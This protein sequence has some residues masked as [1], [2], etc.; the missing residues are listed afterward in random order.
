MKTFKILGKLFILLKYFIP[1]LCLTVLFGLAGF[2]SAQAITVLAALAVVK[3]LGAA[4]SLSYTAIFVAMAVCGVMRGFLRY[5][6]HLTG[7][8]TA[9]KLLAVL[10]DKLFKK[11]RELSP[12]KLE[13]REKGNL[14]SMTTSDIET[15]EVFYAHTVAPII[16]YILHCAVMFVFLGQASS[17]ALAALSVA[18]YIAV[19]VAVPLISGKKI[20]Q[21]GGGYRAR[22]SVF[23]SMFMDT[24]YG[25]GV[26][27]SM[28]K[29]KWANENIVNSSAKIEEYNKK[30]KYAMS[31][32]R[33]AADAVIYAFDLLFLAAGFLLTVQG[34]SVYALIVAF[35]AFIGSYGPSAALS[36]LPGNLS[37][38]IASGDR[39]L[40]LLAEQPQVNEKTDGE[41]FVYENLK[42]ENLKFS[43]GGKSVL[44]GVNCEFEKNKIYG[45]CGD[46]GCGKSTFLKVIMRFWDADGK[47][48]YNGLDIK[49]INTSSLR[50]NISYMTQDTHIFDTTLRENITLGGDFSQTEIE[51]ACR[52]AALYNFI[53]TLSGGLDSK[54]GELGGM[55]SGGERQRIGL[56]RMFLH[57]GGLVL[58]DEPTSNVDA[59]SEAEILKSIQ[60]FKQ[61]RTVI[62]VSHR[63]SSLNICDKILYMKDGKI[64]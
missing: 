33:A 52:D 36:A 60:K 61:G 26:L 46:S 55:F 62:M 37:N 6:E 59:L 5:G 13:G 15:L 57:G 32:S 56:A 11:L 9:F 40:T 41:G 49:D 4:V 19:G 47:I 31:S 35:V 50:Q 29:T 64:L 10:R 7:H 39:I 38:T 58:L 12:A 14:I 2:L 42:V 1:V 51:A 54:A 53:Q 63:E 23:A 24:I 44:N 25:S 3:Y 43:Y 30:M 18:A 28:G 21:H 34:L 22:Y 20:K 8:Y 27:L 48:C 16:I 45:I 17:Y